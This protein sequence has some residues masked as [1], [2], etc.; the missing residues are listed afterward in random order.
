MPVAG[1]D[2]KT[3]SPI[4]IGRGIEVAH[5]MNDVIEPARHH[6]SQYPS[7]AIIKP[8]GFARLLHR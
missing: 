7:R 8:T 2:I 4:K 3:K 5:R 6:G 1:A